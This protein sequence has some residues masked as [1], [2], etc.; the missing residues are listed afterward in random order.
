MRALPAGLPDT[1]RRGTPG[2]AEASDWRGAREHGGCEGTRTGHGRAPDAVS[3]PPALVDHAIE[4]YPETLPAPL[5]AKLG[6][7]DRPNQRFGAV[8][9]ARHTH[10]LGARDGLTNPYPHLDQ[11]VVSRTLPASSE[12]TVTADTAAVDSL[13]DAEG[14]G[15]WLCGGG[16]LA[17][18]LA[19]RHDLDAVTIDT[20]TRRAG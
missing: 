12:L 15:V 19:E 11:T 6:I 3:F 5:R 16:T 7:T 10:E 18:A 14:L 8:I 13:L 20:Y 1:D 9:M 4:H 2:T 17:G